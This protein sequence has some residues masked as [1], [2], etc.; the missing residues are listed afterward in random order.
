MDTIRIGVIGAGTMGER[1]CRVYSNLRHVDFV[2]I[3]DQDTQ[4]GKSVA[5][6]YDT[7]YFE[8]H[9]QLLAKVDAV[10]IVTSTP[11]HFDLAIDALESDTHVLVEKPL[12]KTIDQAKQLVAMANDQDKI[13]CLPVL[14]DEKVNKLVNAV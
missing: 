3:A 8:S 5:D 1:H 14:G 4:R 13:F 2:G 11:A 9:Q 12:T 10:S 7:R 6:I